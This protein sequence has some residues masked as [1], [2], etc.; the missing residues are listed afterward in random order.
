VTNVDF[1]IFRD[2]IARGGVV[3]CIVASGGDVLTRKVTD[4]LTEKVKGIG[5]G[6]LPLTKVVQAA[7]GPEFATGIAKFIQPVFAAL[8]QKSGAKVG[9]TIFFMPGD[10][11]SVAKYLDHVRQS[12]ARTLNLIKPNQWN[13][14]WV[15]EFPLLD[16]DRDE[17]RWVSMHHPFTSAIDEDLPKLDSTDPKVIAGIR[18]KAYDLVLNGTEMAGGSIRIHRRDIQAKI[19]GLLGISE[20]EANVKFEFLMEALRYGAPPHGGIAF[21]LDRWIMLLADQE[22]LRD[23]IA[24]PK[25]GNAV[26]PLT[27]APTPVADKQLDELGLTL[28]PQ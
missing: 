15:N 3:K 10:L 8:T 17:K 6:G 11:P 18:A 9:D 7:S 16:W 19:F 28:R 27:S 13:V 4:D 21:G 14:L 25:T 20:E 22:S 12:L 1:S 26:C 24:Y 5:G 2:A 23:V